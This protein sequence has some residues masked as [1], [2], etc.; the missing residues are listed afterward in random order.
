[1]EDNL[2]TQNR[3]HYK[4]NLQGRAGY[5]P[6][7]SLDQF[8]WITNNPGEF[9][10]C[11]QTT[12]SHRGSDLANRN[13]YDLLG[14]YNIQKPV[15]D[16]GHEFRTEKQSVHFAIGHIDVRSKNWE[17]HGPWGY[18]IYSQLG[19]YNFPVIE[20]VSQ[21]D[22]RLNGTKAI[23]QAIPTKSAASLAQ[24]LGELREGLPSLIGLNLLKG[25]GSANSIGS[26][27]LNYQFGLVPLFNDLKKFAKAAQQSS[28]IIKQY[29][30]DSGRVVRRKR[31][32]GG[33][34]LNTHNETK[35][36]QWENVGQPGQVSGWYPEFWD[37]FRSDG[38]KTES[39]VTMIQHTT[40]RAWFSGAFSYY[41]NDGDDVIARF[42]RYEQLA[43]K[44]LG[45][46]L[47]LE[48]VYQLTPWSW[49]LD[50]FVDL[51]DI[52]SSAS[53]FANDRLV[54]RYGYLM[55]NTVSRNQFT[56]NVQLPSGQVIHPATEYKTE[57]KE[58]FRATP[59]G[60]AVDTSSF[61]DGQCAIL[62]ALGMTKAPR[63]LR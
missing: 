18:G 49:L 23:N 48:T 40:R 47:T 8:V 55:V 24:F 62:G 12:T 45:S 59:Y 42:E 20:D 63:S 11:S 5:V 32:L 2:V 9:I 56:G 61:S 25:R 6:P 38:G 13:V 16:N 58:R 31:G 33:L 52:I 19:Q 4:Y 1:M 7:W 57:R 27:Y 17:Y 22:I 37:R 29:E 30:R 15:S 14:R 60:F 46:R 39:S 41:L 26:E 43:N 34:S 44:L 54:L 50:W 53:A 36:A 35:L 51:G 10:P 21:N 28:K 3:I